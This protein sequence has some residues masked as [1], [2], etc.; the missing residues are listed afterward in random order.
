MT[1]ALH[2]IV[3]SAAER[4]ADYCCADLVR[5][6]T[7]AQVER[8]ESAP[9]WR[10]LREGL[11][12]GLASGSEWVLSVDADVIPA[13]DAVQ[14]IPAC[15]EK[16]DAEV[17]VITCLIQDK[18]MGGM[19][20]GGVRI[21]RARAIP[22]LLEVMPP[23]GADVRPETATINRAA[24]RGW[25]ELQVPAL[26]GL[27][28]YEQYYRDL[29]RKA[30]LHMQKH[31][32]MAARFLPAWKEKAALDADFRAVLAG[33]G[34]ALFEVSEVDCDA[35]HSAYKPEAALTRIGLTEKGPFSYEARRYDEEIRAWQEAQDTGKSSPIAPPDQLAYDRTSPEDQVV[36]RLERIGDNLKLYAGFSG[37]TRAA[38]LH[39]V[40]RALSDVDLLDT[41][42]A[43]EL[44]QYFKTRMMR[45][46][47][48]R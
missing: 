27:H 11:E 9:F 34:D 7:S 43:P 28:D 23:Q 41:F 15:L 22:V 1:H 8:I 25:R 14:R 24:T 19:R 5:Q 31:G 6:T 3:R 18:L 47:R 13:P 44:L 26:L 45:L 42:S 17:G 21:Y 38:A 40:R 12:H 20:F 2:V 36:R 32:Y 39:Q 33:A 30:F 16:A 4:T 48:R 37:K 35:R 29:Y 46:L 10:T